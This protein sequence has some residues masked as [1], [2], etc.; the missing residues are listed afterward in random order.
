MNIMITII[1]NGTASSYFK[2]LK[3]PPT[4]KATNAGAPKILFVE[5]YS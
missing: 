3:P 1:D 2:Q 4:V 5:R